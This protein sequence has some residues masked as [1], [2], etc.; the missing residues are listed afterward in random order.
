MVINLFHENL[1]KP[2]DGKIRGYLLVENQFG[3]LGIGS[4]CLDMVMRVD[5]IPRVDENVISL[6]LETDYGGVAATAVYTAARLGSSASLIGILGTD[7]A[8]TKLKEKL[9]AT[10]VSIDNC[11]TKE[12]RNATSFVV[13][14]KQG[15]R[16]ISHFPGD[17]PLVT[18]DMIEPLLAYMQAARWVHVDGV[19]F[20]ADVAVAEAIRN[21][22]DP[23]TRFSYDMSADPVTLTNMGVKIEEI[24]HLISL[25]DLFIPCKIAAEKLTGEENPENALYKLAEIMGGG[26][27]GITLGDKGCIIYES[28]NMLTVPAFKVKVKDTTGAGDSFHGAFLH[29]L[30]QGWDVEKTA[31]FATAVAALVCTKRGNWSSIPDATAVEKFLSKES[32]E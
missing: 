1:H 9:L 3:V 24:H 31:K 17:N 29:G 2:S 26:I 25:C 23:S 22:G 12:G 10:H 13:V 7:E 16:A 27:A 8:G 20:K 15:S 6:G 19:Y 14:D 30:C 32:P 28:G 4:P 18:V 5:R 11:F 21:A